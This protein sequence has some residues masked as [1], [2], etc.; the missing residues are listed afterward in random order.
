MVLAV[1]VAGVLL[2]IALLIAYRPAFLGIPDSG[3]YIDAARGNLLSDPVH[4]AGYAFFLRVLHPFPLGLSAV[5]I[6]QHALGIV[7]AL[8]LFWVGWKASRQLW[9]ALVP[10][11]VVLFNGLQLWTEHTPLSDPLFTFLVAATLAA[12]IEAREGRASALVL[13][14]LLLAA[15]TLVRT[16]GLLLVPAMLGWLLIGMRAQLR[17]RAVSA[18]VVLFAA[19]A[20]LTAYVALQQH[21]SGVLGFTEADG[22]ITYAIAAPFADCSRFTPPAGTRGLCQSTPAAQRPSVNAYLW[23]FPDHAA[24]LVAVNRAAVSPA[25]REFGPM[26][27]GNGRLASFGR[28]AILHQPLDYL[29]QVADNFSAFWRHGPESFL[30]AAD[31]ADPNVQRAA[32]AYYSERQVSRTGVG[33][34][35]WYGHNLELDGLLVLILLILSVSPLL[36]QQTR[37]RAV[38]V[39]SAA[40]GWLLL[41]GSAL[42]VTDPRYVLPALGPLA[43]AASIGLAGLLPRLAACIRRRART[44]ARRFSRSAA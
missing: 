39:L 18:L 6:L 2:R 40:V 34:I 41:G 26:P 20:P 10:A 38:G 3:T 29:S 32:A 8:L 1:F 21:H 11:A 42:V 35:D 5:A 31:R 9:V 7:S 15:A 36:A 30:A 27:H 16:V 19:L 28:R 4:P 43:V 37:G 13:V 25:W 44:S 23:G 12:A 24:G 14:G 33:V 22:R 17:R